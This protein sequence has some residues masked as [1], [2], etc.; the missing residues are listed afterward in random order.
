MAAA[1]TGKC[2]C[3]AVRYTV[4][5]VETEHHACHCGICRRWAG[6]PVFAAAAAGVRF[7]GAESLGRFSSSEWAERGFCRR[8]GSHLFYYLKPAD[9]YLMSVGSFDDPAGF[10]L[11]REIY[12]DHKPSGY[13]FAGELPKLTEAQVIAQFAQPGEK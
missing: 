9:Q 13:A 4:E 8:C 10:T 2:L 6:A 3:G 11:A 12:I 5:S 7:E 1:K